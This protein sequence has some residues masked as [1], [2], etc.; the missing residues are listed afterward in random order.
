MKV[1]YIYK[2][3]NLIN[4]KYYIGMHVSNSFTNNYMGSGSLI[5]KAI[6]KYGIENFSKEILACSF[7]REYLAELEEMFI[8]QELVNDKNCYNLKL[9]GVGGWIQKSPTPDT[10][11]KISKALKGRA[12]SEQHREN[13]SK[14]SSYK[15][16]SHKEKISKALKGRSFSDEHK[17]H[18]KE[19]HAD[20]SGS[21][22]P[23]FG[24]KHSEETKC[25]LRNADYSTRTGEHH[26][27]KR[28]ELSPAGKKWYNDGTHTFFLFPNDPKILENNLTL[29]RR[30]GV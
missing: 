23:F 19:N 3:T 1:Y 5:K 4:S 17:K 6:S 14:A 8:T 21:S 13:L 29:G 25:K 26:H 12:F 15:S 11:E 2:I 27:M 10:R 16:Q 20:F 22:N 30:C 18:L 9:G 7:N 24:K 28:P